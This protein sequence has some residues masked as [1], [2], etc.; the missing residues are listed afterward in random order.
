MTY[1]VFGGTLNLAQSSDA[2]C[3]A[4]IILSAKHQ[5]LIKLNKNVTI[6]SNFSGR[7]SVLIKNLSK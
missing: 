5:K 2:A 6:V 3:C 4:Y 7:K 1:N